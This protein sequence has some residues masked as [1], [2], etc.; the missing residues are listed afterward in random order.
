MERDLVVLGASAG[1]VTALLHVIASFPR[2]FP[3][4]VIVVQHMRD[5]DGEHHLASLIDRRTPLRVKWIEQGDRLVHGCVYVAPPGLHAELIDG[6][7]RLQATVR[8]NYV[9]PSIDRL[10]CSTARLHG[11]HVIGALLTGMM[12]DG[13]AGLAAIH[14]AGG[15]T[16][17]EDPDT[18]QART[19]P[20][21]ALARFRPDRVL[22]LE[23][24]GPAIV[25][26]VRSE[27]PEARP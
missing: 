22:P 19:L 12:A 4:S 5:P 27:Q 7:L 10:F 14:A 16:I 26:L 25:A 18:A 21:N 8:E 2:G 9:R 1:G 20:E 3:A 6:H 23:Q 13:V 11:R 24:I 17:V 15:Y